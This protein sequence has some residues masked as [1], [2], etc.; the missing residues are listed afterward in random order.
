MSDSSRIGLEIKLLREQ[1]SLSG[2]D[3]ADKVGLSQSQ[4]SRLESG[5]R[6]IDASLL[7]RLARAL[8]VH[9][10]TFFP[11]FGDPTPSAP[12]PAAA[13]AGRRSSAR[14]PA[15]AEPIDHVGRLIRTERRQKH[16]TADDIARKINKPRSWILDLEA[17]ATDLLTGEMV[18][19]LSKAL[20]VDPKILYDAQRKHLRELQERMQRL[21][22]AYADRTR[23]RFELDDGK[24]RAGV[25]SYGA[26]GEQLEFGADGLPLGDVVDYLYLPDFP[27]HHFAL[28]LVG[29]EMVTKTGPSFH[30][31]DHL[32]FSIEREVRHRDFALA[33]TEDGETTF[34]QVFFDP[35]GLVRL[36]PR[37]LDY[38]PRQYHRE[39]VTRL[40]RLAARVERL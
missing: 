2:K 8:R 6:R 12:P 39:E 22:Q 34:R 1:Q 24:E 17:G 29:E 25:P 26:L 10:S 31:G 16:L 11:E 21:E 20:K 38:A 5:Q 15:V 32:V 3:L 30:E 19:R 37:N 13:P 4:M 35:R 40:F 23:G 9:P 7:G 27:G 14:L 18:Q 36:Q 33:V 28:T